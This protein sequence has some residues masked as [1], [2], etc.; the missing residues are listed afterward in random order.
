MESEQVRS[1]ADRSMKHPFWPERRMSPRIPN[2]GG[3]SEDNENTA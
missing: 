3:S 1:H 2:P